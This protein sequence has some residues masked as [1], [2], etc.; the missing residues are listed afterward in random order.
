MS[1]LQARNE[2]NIQAPVS[3]IWA[4][5]TDIHVLHK[6]NPG[7]IKAE[8]RMDK[9]GETRNC[10]IDNKGKK[11][12]M[13]ERLTELVHE[14]KTVWTL[15]RDTLGMSKMLKNTQ[16]VF[17]LEKL[18]DQQ[19]KVI[20]ETYYQPAHLIAKIMNRLMMKKM[21]AKA[22]GEILSNIKSLTEN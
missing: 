10:Q 6:I 8:G 14:K 1:T 2:T 15:E 11:G 13:T 16:F 5:I 17:H 19:T 21:I 22:Q 3:R 9:Q 20:S 18:G 7:V 4:I 12:S